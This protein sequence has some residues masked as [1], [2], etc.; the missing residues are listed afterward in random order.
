M[1]KISRM[2]ARLLWAVLS[3]TAVSAPVSAAQTDARLTPDVVV[4]DYGLDMV[5]NVSTND[6]V[7]AI[8]VGL[9]EKAPA[10]VQ[11]DGEKFVPD[12]DAVKNS[13][14]LYN[15]DGTK[16]AEAALT[17]STV[18][19]R[20]DRR[21]GMQLN[22]ACTFYYVSRVREEYLYSS[23]TVVPAS[24]M[25]FEED[26]VTFRGNWEELGQLDP[27][28]VQDTDRP[29][30]NTGVS[31]FDADNV[32][33]FD[34][35]YLNN[36]EYS[37][38]CVRKA[39]GN[40]VTAEES[41]EETTEPGMYSTASAE[42][43]FSGTGFDIIGRTDAHTGC[44]LVRVEKEGNERPITAR[45]GNG[46]EC[47]EIGEEGFVVDTRFAGTEDSVGTLYQI[48]VVTVRDLP[49]DTYTVILEAVE[50]KD[51]DGLE[52]GDFY[53]DAVRIFDP[54]GA[55]AGNDAEGVIGQA[56]MEDREWSPGCETFLDEAMKLYGAEKAF[57]KVEIVRPNGRKISIF[58]YQLATPEHGL[59]LLPGYGITMEPDRTYLSEL[60]GRRGAAAADMQLGIKL[61][62][63]VSTTVEITGVGSTEVLELN[64]ASDLNFSIL[65]FYRDTMTITNTG[66]GP[67][68]LTAMKVTLIPVK[69][70]AAET[71][72]EN[73][74]VDET[75]PTE[76]APPPDRGDE[77]ETLPEQPNDI[78]ARTVQ[79][80][81]E[82]FAEVIV[83]VANVMDGISRLLHDAAGS[84]FES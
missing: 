80:F 7:E 76:E 24:T 77:D 60:Q 64:T 83:R 58:D 32:Y 12:M 78:I 79:F 48:P 47:C 26:F 5:V 41:G 50:D 14:D 74:T 71:P 27:F 81:K 72:T 84:L 25:Y 28:A 31:G 30:S 53:L 66:D 82:C 33:G 70:G 38:N 34:S 73:Q 37:L 4:M 43:T 62:G 65:K 49:Y 20:L 59:Y 3:L 19:I 69:S 63:N 15:D 75:Q 56:Y 54:S 1:K 45:I 57:S 21:G 36:R 6:Y 52:R 39:P 46:T 40:R 17:G 29:G 55:V 8:P 18:R 61:A 11:I 2:T 35:A 10:G 44:V 51:S 68:M 22:Q 9:L 23:V 42:F 67:I 13:V 16:V